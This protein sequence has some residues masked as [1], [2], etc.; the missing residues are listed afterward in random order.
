MSTLNNFSSIKS[1]F[2]RAVFT[3]QNYIKWNKYSLLE[4]KVLNS[5]REQKSIK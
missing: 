1:S 4:I 3:K 5:T 2:L